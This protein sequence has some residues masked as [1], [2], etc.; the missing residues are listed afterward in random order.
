MANRYREKQKDPHQGSTLRIHSERSI[1]RI[2]NKD[3]QRRRTGPYR[4]DRVTR[5]DPTACHLS[6]AYLY[7][8]VK[9]DLAI[10]IC[11]GNPLVLYRVSFVLWRGSFV[12]GHLAGYCAAAA[13]DDGRGAGKDGDRPDPR[14]SSTYFDTGGYKDNLGIRRIIFI[15]GQRRRSEWKR[16][17]ADDQDRSGVPDF[18]R[19]S[20]EVDLAGAES[21]S[22]IVH[23][24]LVCIFTK[25]Y[26]NLTARAFLDGNPKVHG[27][28]IESNRLRQ[29]RQSKK[30]AEL[31]RLIVTRLVC[32]GL[33][34]HGLYVNGLYVENRRCG[35][36]PPRLRLH[37]AFVDEVLKILTAPRYGGMMRSPSHLTNY[38]DVR[39]DPRSRS[40]AEELDA[41]RATAGLA[42]PFDQSEAFPLKHGGGLGV[43]RS[44][45][46]G[47]RARGVEVGAGRGGAGRGGFR[48][49]QCSDAV[50]FSNQWIRYFSTYASAGPDREDLETLRYS[51]T[52]ES[53]GRD[54]TKR[55][56]ITTPL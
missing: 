17:I 38:D 21:V 54:G 31:R 4:A 7:A 45:P 24:E 51:A 11:L 16:Q 23:L 26:S 40:P 29:K 35:Q 44:S 22:D 12:G 2:H 56:V 48:P 14:G 42:V 53:I 37:H 18:L 49:V 15:P 19:D 39:G 8:I 46:A 41:S 6:H 55:P 20:G 5:N 52:D 30:K 28:P 32:D 13:R 25:F 47:C 34:V 36:Q 1:I 50:E 43:S 27:A 33:Y 3:P 9:R 10:R